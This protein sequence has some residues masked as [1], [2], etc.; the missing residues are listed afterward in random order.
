MV[1]PT[2]QN[3]DL[4]FSEKSDSILL[5]H[6]RERMKRSITQSKIDF[7]KQNLESCQKAV[8]DMM[9]I[10]DSESIINVEKIMKLMNIEFI[11]SCLECRRKEF[12]GLI[13]INDESKKILTIIPENE[14]IQT[15]EKVELTKIKS[16]KNFSKIEMPDAKKMGNIK[17]DFNIMNRVMVNNT[18][19]KKIIFEENTMKIENASLRNQTLETEKSEEMFSGEN[20]Q[21]DADYC[22]PY[23]EECFKIFGKISWL[24]IINALK[25]DD[26]D[27]DEMY[28]ICRR[29]VPSFEKGHPDCY[30]PVDEENCGNM[31]T[32]IYNSKYYFFKQ[33]YTI[34]CFRILYRF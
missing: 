29:C 19:K 25:S 6:N 26:E 15:T 4:I 23:R 18:L 13:P 9:I 27:K 14:D 5:K 16:S 7:C 10:S 2:I 8:K 20:I 32:N 11:T 3:C 17:I 21:E 31:I 24:Q 22:E 28:N 30:D 12:H 34:F 33:Y 1:N